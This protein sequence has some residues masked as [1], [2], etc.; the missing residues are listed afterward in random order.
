M[1]IRYPFMDE[2]V[3]DVV[4]GIGL[5]EFFGSTHDRAIERCIA[6]DL[7]VPEY[8]AYRRSKGEIMEPLVRSL[9]S[10]AGFLAEFC[11]EM[12][13]VD[14]GLVEWCEV[15]DALR[16]GLL[17]NESEADRFARIYMVERWLR[18]RPNTDLC[19]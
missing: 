13:C 6:L 14:V 3:V 8:I 18:E 10:G 19:D 11:S 4:L 16:L 2:R 15:S 7:G 9:R 5:T 12:A 17:G 1:S